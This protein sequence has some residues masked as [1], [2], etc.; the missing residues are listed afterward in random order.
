MKWPRIRLPLAG[1]LTL[2]FG[3]MILVISVTVGLVVEDHLQTSRRE[4]T[5]LR[6]SSLGRNLSVIS[7]PYLMNY[8]YLKLQQI[9]DDAAREPGLAR[10]LILDKEGLI[11]GYSGQRNRVGRPSQDRTSLLGHNALEPSLL[12]RTDEKGRTF[13]EWIGPVSGAREGTRWG[14]VVVSLSL[15]GM[16]AGTQQTR[17]LIVQF[18][19]GGF[20]LALALSHLLARRV[21]RPL[22]R[23]VDL[24][25]ALARGERGEGIEIRTGDEIEVLAERFQDAAA[26]LEKQKH[27][28]VVAHREL[29]SLNA[30]LE[31]KVRDRTEELRAEREKYRLIVDASPDPLCLIQNGSFRFANR[32]F[33]ETFGY[34]EEQILG[35][36]FS[37]DTVLHPDFA[38]IARDVLR[39]AEES[40]IR[41]DTEWVG[42]GRGGRRLEL[43]VRGR[44]V[45]YQGSPAVELL[46]IDHTDKKRLLRQVVQ[47]ERLRAIGEMTAM[48]AHNFNNLLAVILG[49]AQLLQAKAKDRTVHRGLEIIRTAAIQGGEIVRRI[50]D[51]TVDSTELRFQEVQVGTILREVATY[52]DNYWRVTGGTGGGPVQLEL[53]L[54]EAPAVLGSEPL[55]ADLFKNVLVNAAEAMPS[56]GR[57]R[58]SSECEDGAIRIRIEDQGVG[59]TAE[60]RRRAFDPFFTTKGPRNRGLGLSACHGIVQ[61]HRGRIDLR[62]RDGGG[63]LVEIQLPVRQVA[64]GRSSVTDPSVV[65]LTEEQASARK[66]R[67]RVR[68]PSGDGSPPASGIGKDGAEAA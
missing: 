31:Q 67:E 4:E 21:T 10:V 55:L 16:R 38:A 13:L 46:W 64:A 29:E 58:V 50:Q 18:A 48:V 2:T 65:L 53:D 37:L 35:E 52:L 7:L 49:R 19:V 9:A 1:R 47:N 41:I 39:R 62:P 61:R 11:A 54:S 42:I 23:L 36:E 56:G 8:D 15:Q 66:E 6:L 43:S 30:T 63:T 22:G 51:Y 40:G 60:V 26:S 45:R 5:E 17:L 33:I 24:A 68:G 57:I 44:R 28:L 32:A 12:E 20:L 34:A 59:L 3:V 25:A 27:E 14:T